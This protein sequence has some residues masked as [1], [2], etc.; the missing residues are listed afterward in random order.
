ME[1]IRQRVGE[2][3]CFVSIDIDAVD[4]A[5]APGTG[6]PEVGGFTS[7][8]VLALARGL[9]GLDIRGADVVEVLPALDPG[10]ITAYLAA[11]LMHELISL[12]AL[13][14]RDGQPLAGR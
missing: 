7:R 5:Y 14:K 10:E 8:E 4:P 11:N 12:L 9:A 13:R 2:R 3:P 1:R 6:T